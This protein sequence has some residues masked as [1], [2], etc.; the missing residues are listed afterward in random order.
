MLRACAPCGRAG[1][2]GPR[3]ASSAQ[4]CACGD[5]QLIGVT[6][7]FNPMLSRIFAWSMTTPAKPPFVIANL[8]GWDLKSVCLNP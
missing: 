1:P 7:Q 3:R 6:V 4:R 8:R 2:P 5:A